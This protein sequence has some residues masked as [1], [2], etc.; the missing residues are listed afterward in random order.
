[1]K[2]YVI[3]N[4]R[5]F[6]EINTFVLVGLGKNI[7]EFKKCTGTS[8][9]KKYL[10]E[11]KTNITLTFQTDHTVTIVAAISISIAHVCEGE[12]TP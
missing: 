8:T 1:M 3:G 4:F 9:A 12:R 7:L 10:M 5:R 6:V 2:R 11:K